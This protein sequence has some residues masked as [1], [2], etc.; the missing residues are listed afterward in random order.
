M[1]NEDR[2][3]PPLP[4]IAAIIPATPFVSE[5]GENLLMAMTVL[6]AGIT[7]LAWAIRLDTTDSQGFVSAAAA[8]TVILPQAF[9]ALL[10]S[11][12]RRH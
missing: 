8:L 12:A 7:T 4:P 10:R 3:L 6:V 11:G 9:F 2:Y 1:S 5:R